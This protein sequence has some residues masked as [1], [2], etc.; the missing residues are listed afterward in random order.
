MTDDLSTLLAKA[1]T[2]PPAPMEQFL[3]TIPASASGGTAATARR[4]AWLPGFGVA[5]AACLVV[6]AGGA[7]LLSL[8]PDATLEAAGG[9][10]SGPVAEPLTIA[11]SD[12]DLLAE[13][14]GYSETDAFAATLSGDLVALGLAE[15]P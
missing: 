15:T 11:A 12:L 9:P 6:V 14:A 13:E 3:A 4:L 1:S 5:A 10:A 7:S 8:R 2:P